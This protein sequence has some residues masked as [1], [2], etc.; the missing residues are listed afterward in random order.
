MSDNY[1]END[2]IEINIQKKSHMKFINLNQEN[3]KNAKLK[4]TDDDI[5]NIINIK[6]SSNSDKKLNQNKLNIIKNNFN[7]EL[8]TTSINVNEEKN[9]NKSILFKDLI[10]SDIKNNYSNKELAL[11]IKNEELNKKNKIKNEIKKICWNLNNIAI[12]S[13]N[14][15]IKS[16]INKYNV[17]NCSCKNERNKTEEH[18]NNK[19]VHSSCNIIKKKFL[20]CLS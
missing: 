15:T 4:N 20:C 2:N 3:F 10:I 7:S 13:Q 6:P 1:H 14:I 17:H 8:K 19:N 5:V 11:M 12:N 9:Q 18:K 16:N